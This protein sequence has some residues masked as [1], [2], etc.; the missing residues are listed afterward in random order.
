MALLGA[1]QDETMTIGL[2]EETEICLTTDETM[3]VA[4]AETEATVMEVLVEVQDETARRAQPH[5]P[6]RRSLHQI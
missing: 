3:A 4:D 5:H 6:R 2:H 1:T